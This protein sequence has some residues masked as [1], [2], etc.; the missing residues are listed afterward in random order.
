[1]DKP[2]PHSV[3]SRHLKS[4]Y[5]HP[6]NGSLQRQTKP[7]SLAWRKIGHQL[8][9]FVQVTAGVEQIEQGCQKNY[10]KTK[11]V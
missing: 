11:L 3:E 6:I 2:R 4:R 10:L 7:R 8:N 9:W 1:M 5:K